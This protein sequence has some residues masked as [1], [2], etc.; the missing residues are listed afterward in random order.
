M[1]V[2]SIAM[3]QYIP[4]SS[5]GFQ[6]ASAINP[7]FV[8]VEEFTD[9]K[10]G[11]RYQWSG[12][13]DNAPKFLNAMANFRLKQPVDLVSNGVRISN[14]DILNDPTVIPR[15][16]QIIH[17]FGGAVFYEKV[18]IMKRI[19]GGINYSFNYPLSKSLRLAVGGSAIV[20]N[21]KY[22][23]GDVYL[24][25]EA[26]ADQFYEQLQKNSS[27]H[28][29]LNIRAGMLLYSRNFYVGFSYLSLANSVL[30]SSDVA[31]SEPFYNGTVEAG[32]SLQA[33][34]GLTIKPSIM[35]LLLVS[36][37]VSINYNVKAYI[38]DKLWLGL[39]YQDTKSGTVLLGFN[40]NESMGA[41]YSYDISMDGF[42]QFGDG[43]HELVLSL[44]LNNFKRM[45]QY[46]W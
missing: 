21:I 34:P 24:G 13:G 12:F 25:S 18:G 41:S 29:D 44:R 10:L 17:G 16:K 35:A 1:T 7:A 26:V 33:S 37:D 9:I 28:T 22:G 40:F 43:S 4:N 39:A 45:G 14:V 31:F 32:V 27:N 6:F 38:Q 46:T 8:G 42:K 30:K 15:R 11:G 23:I 36:G 19:G 5:Q 2:A 20:E 3:A